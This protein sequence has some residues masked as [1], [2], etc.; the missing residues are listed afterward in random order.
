MSTETKGVCEVCD[1]PL[2]TECNQ[3]CTCKECDCRI[4]DC[5][6]CHGSGKMFMFDSGAT[7]SVKCPWCNGEG[8]VQSAN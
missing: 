3:C 6:Y 8:R 4:D 5:Q 7:H 2:C 1:E